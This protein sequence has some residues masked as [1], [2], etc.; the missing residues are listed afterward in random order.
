MAVL[1][2]DTFTRTVALGAGWGT[3][4]LGPAYVN[5]AGGGQLTGVGVNGS[6]AVVTR[7]SGMTYIDLPI[8]PRTDVSFTYAHSHPTLPTPSTASIS[9]R[10]I[11]RD[12]P[13]GNY[14]LR[15]WA[16]GSGELRFAFARSDIAYV[17]TTY[18]WPGQT[19]TAGRK[20]HVRAEAYGVSPTNLRARFWWDGDPEP[21]TW[22]MERT[23]NSDGW[24]VAGI[25][26]IYWTAGGSPTNAPLTTYIDSLSLSDVVLPITPSVRYTGVHNFGSD[27]L[28]AG[29]ILES[30]VSAANAK[31]YRAGVL[32]ATRAY[33]VDSSSKWGNTTFNDLLP[34]TEYVIVPEVAGTERTDY[35]VTVRTLPTA[36]ISFR[37]VTGSCQFTGSN[38]PVWDRIKAD[39]PLFIGHQGDLHYGDATT[40]AGWRLAHESSLTTSRFMALAAI[41]PI[42][43]T[44]DNHDRVITNP[45]GTGTGLNL[46]E[47]DPATQ[48]GWRKLAGSTDFSSSDTI[49]RTWVA[50]RVRFIATDMWSVRDDGDGDPAPRTFLGATQKAWFK[51][52]L[53]TAEEPII[54]WF[55]QWTAR[56]N[57]NGR[58][59]SFPEESA[60]LEAYIDARPGVKSRMIMIGGD[61]H[62]L[63]A[64]DGSR[65]STGMRF[66]G[67]PSLNMSGFNRSGD[68]GDGGTGWSIANEGMRVPGDSESNWGGYSRVNITDTGSDTVTFSWEAVRVNSVGTS[69]VM[70]TFTKSFA[71]DSIDSYPLPFPGVGKV[72]VNG[73]G[74]ERVY[75]GN[76]LE[77]AESK[78]TFVPN[79]PRDEAHTVEHEALADVLNALDVRAAALEPRST[80]QVVDTLFD[81]TPGLR[82]GATVVVR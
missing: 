62:S 33:T 75:R 15:S 79:F 30:T 28:T 43:W 21:S 37:F 73:E 7:S 17:G 54:V 45:T 31:L 3:P 32:Q 19:Y 29:I 53:D 68:A 81:V 77:W 66:A 80:L 27:Y 78:D 13:A 56:N 24:Q 69:D 12:T 36:P 52:V 63:Q 39:A 58:W 40:E 64:D 44:M 74:I 34:G 26:Q 38:H 23:D 82:P 70:A 4:D 20:L 10:A 14:H 46:G 22:D 35:S 50:G 2:N 59:N 61:S 16:Y 51:N 49:G 6:A 71:A 18:T 11:V 67:I 5:H 72:L 9:M 65:P 25:P 55:A 1:F 76:V 57:A 47:T 8:E 41:S 48:L 42:N 60:E